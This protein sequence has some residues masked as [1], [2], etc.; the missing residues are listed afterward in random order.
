MEKV[1]VTKPILI[2]LVAALAASLSGVAFLLGRES[3][4][5]EAA[6]VST[7]APRTAAVAPPIAPPGFAPPPVAVDAPAAP[8]PAPPVP[9][10]RSAPSAAPPTVAGPPPGATID[11]E[12]QRAIVEYFARVDRLQQG[13][14]TDNSEAFAGQLMKAALDGDTSGFERFLHDAELSQSQLKAIAAPAPCRAYHQS[15]LGLMA[16]SIGMLRAIRSSLSTGDTT[17]LAGVGAGAGQLQSRLQALEAEKKAIL[18]AYR[19]R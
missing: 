16:E 15:A 6:R 18:T 12:L 13:P 7:M 5:G 1:T 2:G 19:L 11:P 4:R 8:T 3:T 9:P 17:A 14:A 10:L